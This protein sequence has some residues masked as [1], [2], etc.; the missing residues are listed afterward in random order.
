M[1]EDFHLINQSPT[2]RITILDILLILWVY[3]KK[4][5]QKSKIVIDSGSVTMKY[6]YW[7]HLCLK[8]LDVVI[9]YFYSCLNGISFLASS[10]A[11]LILFLVSSNALLIDCRCSSC[12]WCTYEENDAVVFVLVN[13]VGVIISS[14]FRCGCSFLVLDIPLLL[15][16]IWN[17]NQ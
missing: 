17:I 10:V 12:C 9:C 2:V 11:L 13:V 8:W 16:R 6:I 4:L 15:I 3:D 1:L 7:M 14:S 5:L